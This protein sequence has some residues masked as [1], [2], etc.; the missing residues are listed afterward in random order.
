[1]SFSDS[2]PR[3]LHIVLKHR[4]RQDFM[5][6]ALGLFVF[7]SAP[8]SGASQ[9]ASD[10]DAFVH[11]GYLGWIRDL[12]TESRPGDEWPSIVVDDR[13][14]QDYEQV[15]ATLARD[16]INEFE[17]W[18]LAASHSY[19]QDIEKSADADRRKEV[20]RII[21]A[22]HKQGIKVLAGTGIYS[23]GFDAIVA[24][25]PEISCRNSPHVANP[26]RALSWEYQKRIIDYLFSFGVDGITL[27]PGDQGRC[28]CGQ[29]C[30]AMGDDAA[31]FT[32]VIQQSAAYVRSRYPKAMLGIGGY[33][34]D[35]SHVKDPG[36]LRRLNYGLDYYIDVGNTTRQIRPGLI[37]AIA[38]TEF[39]GIAAPGVSPPQHLA[40]DHWF[41][42]TFQH[43]IAELKRLHADGG[44]ASENFMRILANPSDEISMRLVARYESD[45]LGDWRPK[46]DKLIGEIYG[47]R[48]DA[49]RNRLR[50]IFIEAES[51]Y[52]DNSSTN[53]DFDIELEPLVGKDASPLLYLSNR[54]T[55][56]QRSAYAARMESLLAEAESI[57][58]NVR[59]KERLRQAI[60]CIRN[61]L[62]DV[63]SVSASPG[64]QVSAADRM[65]MPAK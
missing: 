51:A 56:T 64:D 39:G 46:L 57:V 11:R 6:L 44:R 32:A 37:A 2:N 27:Q 60:R 61:V 23:W 22:V 7:L 15:S 65:G 30:T 40:R 10:G 25:H 4:G 14:V 13:L 53:L 54:M 1:M 19:S 42:P 8:A 16:G 17:I 58:P 34:I 62:D 20:A 26:T 47:P 28:D 55:Q 43:Q 35:L 21:A 49:A 29:E 33:G 3:K 59:N 24:A 52:F 63:R 48:T 18:G 12:A 31:Y 5:W 45:P 9:Q 41:L 36:R 38:P 50:H